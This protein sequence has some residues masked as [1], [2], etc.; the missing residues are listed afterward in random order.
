[1]EFGLPKEQGVVKTQPPFGEVREG[2]VALTPQGVRELV[3]RGHRVYVERGAGERAGFPDGAYEEAGA[4]LVSREEAFGRGEVVLKVGRPTLE[5]IALLRPG[6][7]VMA[8]MHLAV[9]ESS[10]VEAMAE[11]GLTAIGYELIGAGGRRPVLKAMSEIAGRLAP[12]IAG[13][14]LEAPFGPGVLLSGLPGIP[15]ADVVILGAGVLGRAAARSFLGMGASVYLLD[16]ELS[17]LEEASKEAKGAVTAL[18]TQSRLERYA[19]FA[20]VLVGAVAVPGE[21][22][23]LLLSRALLSRMR[24]GTVLLDF[25][26]DQGGIAETSRVGVYQE[27]GI[28]HFCLPNVPALVPRTSSH[29]LTATLLP[30]LLEVEEDPLGVPEL[31]QGAYLLLGQKGGHLE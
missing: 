20:D 29:A 21:R 27:M 5:E 25:A 28:T 7:T 24:P 31:R 14:L 26:I 11:K 6:A 3:D 12:Q 19:A 2:R 23:P 15:P 10:L 17:A 22:A 30:F 16:K 8:F 18:I 13:R 1:M 9:A 4:R